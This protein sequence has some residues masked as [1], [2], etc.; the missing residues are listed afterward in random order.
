MVHDT[1]NV[2]EDDLVARMQSLETSHV[3][4]RNEIEVFGLSL[5]DT[6]NMFAL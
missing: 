6:K 5:S 4:I 2:D 1:W 3:E